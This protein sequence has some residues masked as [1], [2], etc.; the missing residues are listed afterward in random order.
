MSVPTTFKLNTGA[1]IPSIGLGTWQSAP[2]E[3]QAAVSHAL[4]KGGYKHID[5][6][7]CYGNEYEVGAGLAEAFKGGVKRED[8]FVTTKLWSTYH[9][10]VELGLDKS[11]KSLGL[12]YV[13]LFL[14][15]WPVPLN[16]NG[17]H[18]K[19]PK[20]ADGSRDLQTDWTYIKTY[21]EMEK[22]LFTGKVKAIGV[23]NFSVPFL[24][25]LLS[26]TT[27][28]PAVNQIENHPF[29]PQHD[30]VDFC[31]ENGITIT[32]YSPLGSAGGPLLGEE[33]VIKI[34]KKHNVAV[35]TVLL[36]YHTN[37]GN[38]V[39]AKSVTPT[40]IEE[41]N[42]L[43]KLDNEDMKALNNIHKEN[44][45][46]RFVTPPWPVNFGFPDWKQDV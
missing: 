34:A 24:K 31:E 4:L 5:A 44:G 18:D 14:M 25:S 2:G 12:D 40:R 17:N 11:L 7:Y 38:V 36:N 1:E 10:R 37:R 35:G 8:I 46:K 32:A 42:E 27:I 33:S 30:V 43:L 23:S 39:L 3:V 20:L 13:D 28:V 45:T 9:S 6:A 19:F 29:L 15:H 26:Q 21:K 16:P 22:L 41:N